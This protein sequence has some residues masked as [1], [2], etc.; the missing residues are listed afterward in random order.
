MLQWKDVIGWEHRAYWGQNRINL[1]VD[2]TASR[3]YW[4]QLP[5]AGTWQRLEVP[6]DLVGLAGSRING[7][8]FT[9]DGGRATFDLT[10]KRIANSPSPPPTPPGDSVWFDD[11]LPPG[12]ITA[13]VDDNWNWVTNLHY[14]GVKSHQTRF[15]G[16]E[17][18]QFRQ[19]SFTG[20]QT[21][22]QV[23]P[24]DVLF[25]YVYLG[26]VDSSWP[27]YNAPD[28][29]M[30]QWYDGT[31][32]EH[33]AFWGVNFIGAQLSIG[34]QG[35]E[36]Q[37]YMGGLPAVRGWYRLEVPASYVGLEGKLVSGMAFSAFR[38]NSNPFVAWDRSGK[39]AVPTKAPRP[40]SATSGVWRSHSNTYGYAFEM[41]DVA[42]PEHQLE[43]IPFYVYPNQAAGTVPMFRFRKSGYE[44]FYSTCRTCP[45]AEW[46]YEG[47]AFYVYPKDEPMPP[48]T[49]PLYL[50]HDAG[51]KYLLTINQSEGAG[52]S[53][54]GIWAYVPDIRPVP[55]TAPTLLEYT[56]SYLH[57]RDNSWNEL[58]FKIER[59]DSHDGMSIWTEVATVSANTV[60]FKIGSQSYNLYRVR[61][62]NAFG[63]SDYSNDA[64]NCDWTYVI[65][66]P[67]ESAPEVSIITPLNGEIV[68]QAFNIRANAFDADGNGTIEKVEFF[69]N[70]VKLGEVGDAP[71][72]L[73]VN[74]VSRGS[75]ILTVTATDNTGMSTTSSPVVVTFPK[76]DQ[77]IAF[78][79]LSDKTYGD[80]PFQVVG[81][82]SSGLPVTFS[83][84]SGPATLAGN[85]VTI[86]GAGAVTVRASQ[87]GDANYN[88]AANVD[89]TFNVQV[90]QNYSETYRASTDFSTVQ[91][92]RNWYYLDSNG[93]QMSYEAANSWWHGSETY[94]LIWASG[95]H[96]GSYL[97]SVRQ[98]RAPANGSIHIT[99]NAS[100]LA[101]GCGDGVTVSIKKGTQV[102]WQQNID[103]GNDVGFNYD[104]TTTVVTG[105]QINF[106]INPRGDCWCDSTG[107]DP[108]IVLT[109]GS[110]TPFSGSPITLPGTIQIEDFD[111][112][113][114]GIA[115]H[116]TSAGNAGGQYRTN[117]D[118][119]IGGNAGG[120]NVGWTI[121]GEWTK[122][123][124][125]VAGTGTYAIEAVVSGVYCCPNMHVEVDGV[126]VTGRMAV[127]NTG[128]WGAWQTIS[129]AGVN[130]TAGYHVV[131]FVVDSPDSFLIDSLRFV[132]TSTGSTPFSGTPISLPGT[133]QIEDF[134]NGGEGVA[135]HD[136]TAGNAGGQY[137]TNT[138]VDIANGSVGWTVS[139][140]WTAY[141]VNVATGGT[142]TTEAVVS[143]IY[144]C[145]NMHV[146]IDGVNVTGPMSVPNTGGWGTWQTISRSGVNIAAGYHVVKFVVDSPD[147]FLIDSI[148][149][150]PSQ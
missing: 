109:S 50:Y 99:G 35:T 106:V 86:T 107:F 129:K 8:K 2:S 78:D 7:M 53:P 5:K 142:Y 54:D 103:N 63:N 26:D 117:T 60:W 97:N 44:Y 61:A 108:T 36:G 92:Y 31:S 14:T 118:V 87:P 98:W 112:G 79:Q 67:L 52:M 95:G 45:I 147:G 125:N 11:E 133:I 85:T 19:H 120:Y 51:F 39:S 134:D 66:P 29:I 42:P 17:D 23:N 24:G 140:E 25:T 124:V 149:I 6:A 145:P 41:P 139:G 137:R 12:A 30:L 119:D 21:P 90:P 110:S 3:R 143:G 94:L 122:Y 68:G 128:G 73:T 38:N 72:V 126:D 43:R 150:V 27:P 28:Q 80:A 69:A 4:G 22:M 71:Y 135:Y 121:S 141:S 144:C 37:R 65:D 132:L 48:G 47:I 91:G 16:G 111:N 64:C 131:K 136:T 88:P 113:G 55:P 116:D 33:R 32:W 76:L 15:D 13:A 1:G 56:N 20:A 57:W 62:Y 74:L 84:V 96:P 18:K 70:G 123:S 83:V 104:L 89:R 75:Y 105:D 34:V 40:L 93:S 148:R 59:D 138:D 130:I 81:T 146:E 127:P 77:T 101:A 10:G 46:Q 9:L 114:E 82:A 49:V 100:D 58:G 115:Y 102:L